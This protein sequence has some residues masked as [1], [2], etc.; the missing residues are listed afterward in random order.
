VSGT[1]ELSFEEALFEPYHHDGAAVRSK[2]GH[3]VPPEQRKFIAWDGEGVNIDG[4]GKPQSYVLFGY[5]HPG[6]GPKSIASDKGLSTEELFEFIIQTG[7]SY[8][9][10]FHI[11]Y[12]FSYDGNMLVRNLPPGILVNLYKQGYVNVTWGRSRYCIRF[13]PNKWFSLTKYGPRYDSKK[14]P[15]DKTTV[16]IFDIFSFFTTS[17]VAAYEKHVGPVPDN[18]V[19]GKSDRDRFTAMF[20][21]DPDKGMEYVRQY[22]DAEIVCVR[23]LAEILRQRLYGAGFRITS[24]HGPGALASYALRTRGTASKKDETPDAVSEA[25]KYGYAGGRF[26]MFRLGRTKG[27][28]YSMDINSAYPF[29]IS[30][31]PDLC[32]G[33]W[34]R[35]YHATRIANFGI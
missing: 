19:Q 29:G 22:W 21:A 6:N 13:L 24:W 11:G 14:N 18:V 23:K 16:K 8:P 1:D 3:K 5:S 2:Q 27:P 26:E 4:P 10:A 12:A 15:T 7:A 25:A 31:L 20:L 34:E 28:I 30:R 35:M 32:V 9:S 33:V 17:F